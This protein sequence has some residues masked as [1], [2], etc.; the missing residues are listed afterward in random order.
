MEIGP[1]V[2]SPAFLPPMEPTSQ[3]DE[4]LE[5]ALRKVTGNVWLC[6]GRKKS[7]TG[8]F[9]Y[10]FKLNDTFKQFALDWTKF[11]E[12][13]APFFPA[14]E[15][16]PFSINKF[17][18]PLKE[19]EEDRSFVEFLNSLEYRFNIKNDLVNGTIE[20]PDVETL[21]SHLKKYDGTPQEFHILP[22]EGSAD[23]LTFLEE[24]SKCDMIVSTGL[25]FVHDHLAHVL[26]MLRILH[27]NYADPINFNEYSAVRDDVKYRN[28]TL[29]K[30]LTLFEK[31]TKTVYDKI[32]LRIAQYAAGDKLDIMKN[33]QE[34]N[35]YR[36]MN[37]L[38]LREVVDWL[39]FQSPSRIAALEKDLLEYIRTKLSEEERNQLGEFKIDAISS[40]DVND[41]LSKAALSCY[42][43]KKLTYEELT[44]L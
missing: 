7:E 38:H 4:G 19:T 35:D 10:I 21:Q 37:E 11:K 1:T 22:S 14:T 32:Y 16:S 39:V 43:S 5:E 31:E 2:P 27:D 29:V 33:L 24:L 26:L 15:P 6:I 3:R 28:K 23:H 9:V 8:G 44:I 13:T 34:F 36:Q 30:V 17:L 41:F 20:L 12:E 25:E 42:E 40:K 18:F